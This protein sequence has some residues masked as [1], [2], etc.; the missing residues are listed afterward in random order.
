MKTSKEHNDSTVVKN[1]FLDFQFGLGL[2]FM[3]CRFCRIAGYLPGSVI[4][5]ELSVN[6]TSFWWFPDF[7]TNPQLIWNWSSTQG[8]I[9]WPFFRF[10]FLENFCN[11]LFLQ[12]LPIMITQGNK[13]SANF[14][15]AEGN[16]W[17]SANAKMIFTG[18]KLACKITSNSSAGVNPKSLNLWF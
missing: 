16:G 14:A 10:I 18:L 1:H 8:S 11:H 17:N 9:Q 5:S 12:I 13:I 3:P 4:F 15:P 7:L 2:L 6:P